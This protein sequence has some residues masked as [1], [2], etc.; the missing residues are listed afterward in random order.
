MKFKTIRRVT[1][2]ACKKSFW[3]REG[4][5]KCHEIKTAEFSFTLK[6]K[7]DSIFSVSNKLYFS[8]I[9]NYLFL[10]LKKSGETKSS[11]CTFHGTTI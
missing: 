3:L 11:H 2:H 4:N 6:E 10:I 5:K 1:V 8:W 9:N 7:V